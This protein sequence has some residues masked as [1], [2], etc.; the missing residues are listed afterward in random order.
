MVETS[1]YLWYFAMIRRKKK[2]S[3]IAYGISKIS[4]CLL[5]PLHVTKKYLRPMT[6]NIIIIPETIHQN[7]CGDHI[8]HTVVFL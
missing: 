7:P 2:Y 8:L 1:K 4:R 5:L 6:V 3:S